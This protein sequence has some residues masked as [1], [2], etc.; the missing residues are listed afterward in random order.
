MKTNGEAGT[1]QVKEIINELEEKLAGFVTSDDW[2]RHLDVVS[3]FHQ[4]SLNNVLWISAQAEQRGVDITRIAGFKTWQSLDR[5]V[6]KGERSF[7]VLAPCRY[8]SEDGEEA[9]WVLRGFR[10]ASVFDISQTDGAELFTIAPAL[11]Q[12]RD[13]REDTFR[14]VVGQILGSGFSFSLVNPE[15]LAGANGATLWEERRVLVRDDVGA[16][17]RLKTTVHELAHVL[18][19]SPGRIDYR[20]NRARCEVEAESVAY[21]VLRHLGIPAD[22]YSLPYVATWSRGNAAIV[23]ETAE[24][25]SRT[26]HLVIATLEAAGTADLAA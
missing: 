21:V 10:V 18:L 19:H 22:S 16:D 6:R 13:M 12:G 11:L 17:Q 26:A 7:K 24:I 5:H 9:K 8:K 2:T 20:A 15:L 3:R 1:L 4:Y 23:R 25:V 14:A